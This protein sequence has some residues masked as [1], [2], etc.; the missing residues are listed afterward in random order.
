MNL[1]FA[2]VECFNVLLRTLQRPLAVSEDAIAGFH[3]C[4]YMPCEAMVGLFLEDAIVFGSLKKLRNLRS[5]RRI[6]THAGLPS[7]A[8][9]SRGARGYDDLPDPPRKYGPFFASRE[10]RRSRLGKLHERAALVELEIASL[11]RELQTG[12]IFRRTALHQMSVLILVG[13]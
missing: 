8:R 6:F 12:L 4:Q 1:V 5:E 9:S 10:Q 13:A 11:D 7:R 3:L 2:A